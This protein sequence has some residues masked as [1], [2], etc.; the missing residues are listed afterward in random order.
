MHGKFR[1]QNFTETRKGSPTK[2][3][4]TV[5]QKDFEGKRDNPPPPILSKNFLH[6]RNFLKHRKI[7]VRSFSALWDKKFSTENRDAFLLC[8]KIFDT[9]F[10]LNAEG[11]PYEF[12]RHCETKNFH[13]KI[14][15][16]LPPPSCPSFFY[17]PENF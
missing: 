13:R 17:I 8:K 2:L 1:D 16:A 7:P 6:N 12:Y 9:R 3:F 5:R 14:V 4:G 10:F 15:I 11:F